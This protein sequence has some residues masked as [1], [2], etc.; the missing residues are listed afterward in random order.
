MFAGFVPCSEYFNFHDPSLV[1]KARSKKVA[2]VQRKSKALTEA[3]NS[4]LIDKKKRKDDVFFD[5]R[6]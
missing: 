5:D 1:K 2:K 3:L 6:K 4:E